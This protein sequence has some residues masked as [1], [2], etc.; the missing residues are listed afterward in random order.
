MSHLHGPF[1][2]PIQFPIELKKSARP[3][4]YPF[5]QYFGLSQHALTLYYLPISQLTAAFVF[6]LTVKLLNP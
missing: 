6:P 1:P 4:A 5:Y 2:F 3:L